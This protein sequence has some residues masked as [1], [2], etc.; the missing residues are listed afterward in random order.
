MIEQ[1]KTYIV[2]FE[3]IGGIES[4]RFMVKESGYKL[5]FE[6]II[7]I[8]RESITKDSDTLCII[9][10][11]RF[12]LTGIVLSWERDWVEKERGRMLSLDKN[13]SRKI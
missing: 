13:R 8:Q 10:D 12:Y 1:I 4:Y 5:F 7:R 2:D 6:E 3:I 11:N 9:I